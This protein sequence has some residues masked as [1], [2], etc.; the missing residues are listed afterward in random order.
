[1]L[2]F[3]RASYLSATRITNYD[4]STITI[5]DYPIEV[6]C[7]VFSRINTGGK[8]LTVFEIMVAKTYDESKGFDLAEKYEILRDGSDEEKLCLN[9]ADFDTI[10]ESTIMQCVAAINLRAIRSKDIL[11]ISR[12]AFI[13]SWDAM[14]SSLFMAIDFIRS[15]L[16]IPVSQLLPYPAVIVPTTYFFHLTGNKKPNHEQARL[17]EQFFYWVGLTMRY[18]SATESK[19]GEDSNKMDSIAKEVM[20]TYL[21]NE[22]TI[23]PN[24]IKETWFSAG[25]AYCK[26]ILCLLAYQGP[27]SFDT[28]GVV[29][30]DNNKIAAYLRRAA[31]SFA[32]SAR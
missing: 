21:S 3:A 8:P 11:K 17:L 27:K 32:T 13:E 26:A 6:A 31:I 24:V 5:K 18:G 22:V 9:A 1:V 16:R 25:N 23:D 20:S 4:F 28:N 14:K 29:I 30:L 10:P 2:V 7:E 12:E 15:E 19:V